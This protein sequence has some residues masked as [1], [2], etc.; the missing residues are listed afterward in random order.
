MDSG[1]DHVTNNPKVDVEMLA[2]DKDNQL[3]ADTKDNA[4]LSED[5]ICSLFG[6]QSMQ[7]VINQFSPLIKAVF[8]NLDSC[9]K[10]D[11]DNLAVKLGI[12]KGDMGDMLAGKQTPDFGEHL[13]GNV[14]KYNLYRG[15]QILTSI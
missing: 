14:K 13:L 10:W 5:E 8:H 3:M 6:E 4:V 11:T 15:K 12:S 9:E 2:A 1:T 7:H